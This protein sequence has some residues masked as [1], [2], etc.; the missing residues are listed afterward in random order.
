MAQRTSKFTEDEQV[1][2]IQRVTTMPE[3]IDLGLYDEEYLH[4]IAQNRNP[5]YEHLYKTQLIRAGLSPE[6]AHQL[7]PILMSQELLTDEE[8]IIKG[9]WQLVIS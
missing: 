6:D 2:V 1:I 7:I 3:I 8:A 4:L 9:F 5:I